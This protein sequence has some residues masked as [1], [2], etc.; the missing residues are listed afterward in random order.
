MTRLTRRRGVGILRMRRVYEPAARSD[1]RGIRLFQF[2]R[3]VAT[4]ALLFGVLALTLAG[5]VHVDRS[6]QLH[7]DGSGTYTLNLGLNDQVVAAGG[8]SL[9]SQMDTCGATAT[10]Q[11]ASFRS[12]EQGGYTIWSYTWSFKDVNT[13]NELLRTALQSCDTSGATVSANSNNTDFFRVSRRSSGFT[14][15]FHVTGQMSFV[16]DQS[17]ANGS[18]NAQLLQDARESFAITM[19]GGITAH[20]GGAV[21]GNT[22]TYTVHVNETATIDATSKSLNVGSL[23][24]L[25]GGVVVLLMLAGAMVLVYRRR[26]ASAR[27]NQLDAAGSFESAA[28]VSTVPDGGQAVSSIPAAGHPHEAPTLADQNEPPDVTP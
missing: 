23:Y 7:S 24:P 5:C 6:V 4:L 1:K 19:P 3:R 25:I 9:R 12:Y 28:T 21:S 14:T 13:L 20:T 8:D 17:V 27:G 2:L 16:L 11:G 18:Q 10:S 26:S 15:S 22:I